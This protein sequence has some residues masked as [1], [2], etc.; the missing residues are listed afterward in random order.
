[1]SELYIVVVVKDNGGSRG[2]GGGD[3]GGGGLGRGC[4]STFDATAAAASLT[5]LASAALPLFNFSLDDLAMMSYLDPLV[6]H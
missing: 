4:E 5:F 2:G 1:L 3:E 6:F